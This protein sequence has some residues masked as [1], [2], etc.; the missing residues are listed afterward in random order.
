MDDFTIRVSNLPK[1]NQYGG[2]P[3]TLKAFLHEH[4]EE[5]IRKQLQQYK[6]DS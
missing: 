4:F 1:D 3:E 2:D 6:E 5:V